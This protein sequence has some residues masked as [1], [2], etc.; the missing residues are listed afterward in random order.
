MSNGRSVNIRKAF[1]SSLVG[2]ITSAA[3]GFI[4]LAIFARLFP[5]GDIGIVYAVMAGSLA[6]TAISNGVFAAVRK[7]I[8]EVKTHNGEYVAIGILFHLVSSVILLVPFVSAASLGLFKLPTQL[9]MYGYLLAVTVGF[10]NAAT[11][12]YSGAGNPDKA[13]WLDT[14]RTMVGLAF[15]LILVA[16][17]L[18]VV[19][20][21]AGQVVSATAVTIVTLF[22]YRPDLR[23]PTRL[24]IQSIGD[25]AAWEATSR[26]IR[27]INGRA[28]VAIVGGLLGSVAAGQYKA[29]RSVS[30]L[31]GMYAASIREPLSLRVS[32]EDSVGEIAVEDVRFALAAIGIFPIPAFFGAL[33]IGDILVVTAFGSKYTGNGLLLSIFLLG[34]VAQSADQ[35]FQSLLYG[36]DAP[37][38]NTKTEAVF[39]TVLLLSAVL[40]G[41]EFGIV[42]FVGGIAMASWLGLAVRV[43][44]VRSVESS[45]VAFPRSVLAEVAAGSVMCA[46]VWWVKKQIAASPGIETVA[47]V[48]L[49]CV[50]YVVVLP[51]LSERIRA[52][53]RRTRK[54]IGRRG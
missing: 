16:A 2:R 49:G 11:E 42:G 21:I 23:L 3:F 38:L 13:V 47:L 39:T 8:S 48:A 27:E 44:A 1:T 37:S 19:A 17:G 45:V 33:A 20:I 40:A 50:I 4:G 22:V 15:Q 24:S 54:E 52:L 12:A 46:V 25:F 18:G 51:S 26:I 14:L 53:V 34:M 36:F 43:V 31:L 29:I 5:V 28:T 7:R 32:A 35:I 30:V 10:F 9:Y 6:V 41:V